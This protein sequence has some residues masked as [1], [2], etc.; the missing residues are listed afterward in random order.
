M[1][2]T[3]GPVQTRLQYVFDYI[4]VG[5]APYLIAHAFAPLITVTETPDL[6]TQIHLR[7]QDKDYQHGRFKSN[8]FRDG[9]NWLAGATQ[10]W[11]SDGKTAHVRA[12]YTYDKE[13]TGGPKNV[14]KATQASPTDWASQ[15]HRFL[16]GTLLPPIHHIWLD[17]GFDYYLHLYDN[18]NSF[19]PSG[20]VVRTD[21]IYTFSVT[22]SRQ[23]T[24]RFSLALQ[25]LRTQ[26][27]SNIATFAYDRNIYAAVLTGQF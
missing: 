10:Y 15:G 25:Y 6:F 22:A 13:I 9:H 5:R 19:S 3:T 16:V 14:S 18:A 1:Q 4:K 24:D 23:I 12:G 8:S 20:D 17:L 11:L 21:K 27:D 26:A 7:Y 2:A